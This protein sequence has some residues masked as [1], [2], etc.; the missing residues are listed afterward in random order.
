MAEPK[1]VPK[2][3]TTVELMVEPLAV[4]KVGRKVAMKAERMVD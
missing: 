3:A 1:V 2:V 4:M